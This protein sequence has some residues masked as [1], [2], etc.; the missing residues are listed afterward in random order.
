MLKLINYHLRCAI[1]VNLPRVIKRNIAAKIIIEG[2]GEEIKI[3]S[4]GTD[5]AF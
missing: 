5:G 2:G 1:A 4:N 3:E